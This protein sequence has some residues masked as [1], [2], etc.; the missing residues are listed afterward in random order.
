MSLTLSVNSQEKPDKETIASIINKVQTTWNNKDMKS[1]LAL[2]HKDSRLQKGWSNPKIKPIIAKEFTKVIE[3]L[4]AIESM[5]IGKYDQA[6]KAYEV[7]T[8][9]KKEGKVI[10]TISFKKEGEKF[11]ILDL[12]VDG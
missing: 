8:V 6:K 3:A 5:K 10:G 1:L 7:T 4:G 2:Y 9:Y 12:D 11:L